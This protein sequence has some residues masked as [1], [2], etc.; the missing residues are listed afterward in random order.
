MAVK[1][2]LLACLS[3]WLFLITSAPLAAQE[4]R[5]TA[6]DI[7]IF[8]K[9]ANLPTGNDP[10]MERLFAQTGRDQDS[11]E[12]V[13]LKIVGISTM[14]DQGITNVNEMS[15]SLGLYISPEEY[16][17][18]NKRKGEVLPAVDNMFNR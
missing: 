8:I 15:D 7:D 14:I 10:A 16:N 9:M 18:V 12:D 5:L 3:G 17:L 6:K 13:L 4:V 11:F 2:F 1:S